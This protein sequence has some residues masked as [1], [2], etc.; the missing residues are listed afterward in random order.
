MQLSRLRPG[1]ELMD[2]EPDGIRTEVDDCETQ[3][4]IGLR[5]GPRVA[6]QVL[7]TAALGDLVVPGSRIF[8]VSASLVASHFL[9]KCL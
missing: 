1:S 9:V 3:I 6:E 4:G 8:F 2:V 5:H 7:L